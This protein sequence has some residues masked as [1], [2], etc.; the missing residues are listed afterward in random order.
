MIAGL[1]KASS[2]Y[3]GSKGVLTQML[4]SKHASFL[5][6]MGYLSE[7]LLFS[8][9]LKGQEGHRELKGAW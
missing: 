4:A 6:K 3:I 1:L 5:R 7:G 9:L 8:I 2:L